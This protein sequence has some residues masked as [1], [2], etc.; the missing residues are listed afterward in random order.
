MKKNDRGGSGR[1]VAASSHTTCR[2]DLLPTRMSEECT[3]SFVAWAAAT[4]R[5]LGL[6]LSRFLSIFSP[7][8]FSLS[9]E[10]LTWPPS[11]GGGSS[12]QYRNNL[13]YLLY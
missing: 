11:G 5:M 7:F 6:H 9:C 12:I 2:G 4:Q 3:D 1:N 8:F 10:R 13:P